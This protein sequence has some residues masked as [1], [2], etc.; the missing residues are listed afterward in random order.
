MIAKLVAYGDVAF[1]R[2]EDSLTVV[3]QGPAYRAAYVD[4]FLVTGYTQTKHHPTGAPRDQ[5]NAVWMTIEYTEYFENISDP[6]EVGG[7]NRATPLGTQMTQLAT[8]VAAYL[9]AGRPIGG[10]LH[11]SNPELPQFPD[12]ALVEP[13]DGLLAE[14]QNFLKPGASNH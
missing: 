10:T 5:Y 7:E 6:T 3:K 9:A 13:F 2:V 1:C 12:I 14:V 11:P 4:S 8:A